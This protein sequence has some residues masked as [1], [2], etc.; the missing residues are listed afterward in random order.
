MHNICFVMQEKNLGRDV[1][2]MEAWE[3]KKLVTLGSNEP[4]P[5]PAKYFGKAKENKE[6]YCEEFTKLHP[7][8]DDP[9]SELIDEV[10]MMVAGG[11]QPHGRPA[12]LARV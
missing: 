12:S 8:V 6:K 9:M 2:E 5:A 11:G 10:A 7:E 3:H 4:R 1:G